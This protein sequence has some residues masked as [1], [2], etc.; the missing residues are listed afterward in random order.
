MDSNYVDLTVEES[1]EGTR[2]ASEYSSSCERLFS[3]VKSNNVTQ[4]DDDDVIGGYK[5]GKPSSS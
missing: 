3:E 4:D 5:I 1:I 2:I